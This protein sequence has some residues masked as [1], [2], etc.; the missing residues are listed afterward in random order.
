[1]RNI[2]LR[3]ML[4]A[5]LIVSAEFASA[6]VDEWVAQIKV[7]HGAVAIQR[8]SRSLPGEIGRRLKENDIIVTGVDSAVGMTFNDNSMLSLG[9]NSEVILRRYSYDPT[10]YIGAF[11]AVV[12]RGSVTVTTGNIITQSADAMRLSTPDAESQAGKP[13]SFAISVE[14]R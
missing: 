5:V 11:D 10:T 9:A 6:S 4:C 2:P 13:G 14:G 1:M 7:S 3:L 12:K 8:D